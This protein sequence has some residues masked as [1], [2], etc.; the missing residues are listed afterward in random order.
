MALSWLLA[1]GFLQAEAP[2]D[3]D[4]PFPKVA[5]VKG[6][7]GEAETREIKQARLVGGSVEMEKADGGVAIFPLQDVLAILPLLPK[8][9]GPYTVEQAEGAIRLY[10]RATPDLLQ[11]AGVGS[12]GM[13][14][15]EELKQ[16]LLE[17][18]TQQEQ[19]ERRN[20]E[21]KEA[22]A[23]AN[24]TK[25]V[26][27]WVAQASDLQASRL[28]KELTELRQEGE[29]LARKSPEQ[30][31]VILQVL[32]A[33]SQVQPKEKGEPLPELSK[34]NEVQPKLIP[35]DLLGWLAGGI[36]ILSFFGLLFGLAFLS[37]SL[38]R[39]KE[40]ALL[41]GIVFGV[42]AAGILGV[43]L[44]TWLPAQVTGEVVLPRVD[45]KMEEL[46]IYLKNRA[47]PVYYFPAKGFSFSAEEW[48][49][50]VL[51][52]LPVSEESVG[53][54]KVKMKEG[55]LWLTQEQWI[56]Q[57][58]LTALGI[59]LPFQLTF[60]GPIPELKDWENPAILKVSLGR[61]PIPDSIAGLLKDSASSVL[62]QGL[63]SG[64]LEGVRLDK[65]DKGMILISVPAAGTRPKYE[66]AKEEETSQEVSQP[67]SAYKRELSAEELAKA[68]IEDKGRE[69]QGKFV[70][71][72]GVV[73]KVSSGSEYF[74]G[75]LASQ[76]ESLNPEKAPAKIKEDGFDIFYLRGADSYGYRKDP[77]F[78]KL[79]IKSD[80]VF[81]MDSYG[82][83]YIGPRANIV[84]QNPLIKKGYR[85]KFMNEG[86]V[87]SERIQN[88]EIE[89]Y[90]I[91]LGANGEGLEIFDPS[92][93]P[94][95]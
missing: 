30:I 75:A 36:I 60:E 26:E 51:G 13:R 8:A 37:S 12:T 55:K 90:G 38:T 87:Q 34:L 14:D 44:W 77:L 1:A 70:L 50:G 53:L 80:G 3:L 41:G 67:V 2:M 81:V 57:Q 33:L 24:L 49:S 7:T 47:R 88:N 9:D 73:E 58:P 74:G 29:A 56:W 92:A 16:R 32:A 94:P 31:D 89:V 64:G 42:V 10:Q 91:T 4:S 43:L 35:D 86:R 48:R 23:K 62:R 85:V 78:I 40:G 27:D 61:W 59:P 82:D 5:L 17:T 52:Y 39:F 11:K 46:G 45:P 71:I 25:E 63:S 28:E 69:F 15:W 18:K 19:V 76:G 20:R 83:V 93:P 65:D 54:F 84:K 66:L 79:V 6:K 68:F 72:E 22:E 95:K 21:A